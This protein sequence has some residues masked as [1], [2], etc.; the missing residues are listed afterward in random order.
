MADSG[1]PAVG[2]ATPK[3]IEKD[4]NNTWLKLN[5]DDVHLEC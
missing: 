4:F 3:L 2:Y 5:T 1:W